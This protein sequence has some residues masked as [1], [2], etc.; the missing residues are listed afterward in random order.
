MSHLHCNK[1]TDSSGTRTKPDD[2]RFLHLVVK[3]RPVFVSPSRR[4]PEGGTGS[5]SPSCHLPSPRSNEE[6]RK[7]S[8]NIPGKCHCRRDSN[9]ARRAKPRRRAVHSHHWSSRSPASHRSSSTLFVPFLLL[10]KVCPY[11]SHQPDKY[12]NINWSGN[13]KRHQRSVIDRGVVTEPT[14]HA[15]AAQ[16]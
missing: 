6:S 2:S 7:A 10:A 15:K 16:D 5:E 9:C 11:D 4:L 3:N 8:D 13:P 14:R 12:T 1:S